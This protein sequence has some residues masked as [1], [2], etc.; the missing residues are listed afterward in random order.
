MHALFPHIQICRLER[1]QFTFT[2]EHFLI[3]HTFLKRR[4]EIR[5]FQALSLAFLGTQAFTW[6]PPE[7]PRLEIILEIPE[8]LLALIRA[9]DRLGSAAWSTELDRAPLTLPY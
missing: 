9:T 2:F 1:R 8:V 7:F 5:Q 6:Y 4:Q 3:T